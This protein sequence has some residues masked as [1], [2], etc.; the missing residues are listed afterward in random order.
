[1]M[2]RKGIISQDGGAL[3]EFAIVSPLLFIILFGFIES[4][5]LIYNKQMVTN[6]SREVGRAAINPLPLLSPTDVVAAADPYNPLL[7]RFGPYEDL[8][9]TAPPDDRA[10]PQN[11]TIRVTWDHYFLIP[12]L[13]RW[14]P[15]VTLESVT[16]VQML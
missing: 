6:A 12:L 9:V 15:S 2:L 8:T 11:I 13:F 5:I 10:Y 4:G 7:L 3:I 16:T 1:M 14:M